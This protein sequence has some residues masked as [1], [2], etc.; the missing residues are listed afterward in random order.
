VTYFR[1]LTG[2]GLAEMFVVKRGDLAA[3][4]T[5]FDPL[6]RLRSTRSPR[7]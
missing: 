5:V 2:I 3:Y 1:R 4:R 7:R 6:L